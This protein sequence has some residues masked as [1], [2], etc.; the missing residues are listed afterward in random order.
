MPSFAHARGGY[1][2]GCLTPLRRHDEALDQLRQAV[3]LDPLSVFLR[4]MLGQVF[5]LQGG[6]TTP[7]K[8]FGCLELD[9]AHLA[10]NARPGMGAPR[11]RAYVDALDC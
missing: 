7:S 8:N 10:G 9:P 6:T 5:S 4:S 3:C 2:L 11:K 1:A